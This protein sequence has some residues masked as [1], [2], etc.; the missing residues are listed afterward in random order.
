MLIPNEMNHDGYTLL[1]LTVWI[2]ENLKLVKCPRYGIMSC[3][4]SPYQDFGTHVPG[5]LSNENGLARL[6]PAM[7]HNLL[8]QRKTNLFKR[9]PLQAYALHG[10]AAEVDLASLRKQVVLRSVLRKFSL[11]QCYC[12]RWLQ[13]RRRYHL[14]QIISPSVATVRVV[15]TIPYHIITTISVKIVECG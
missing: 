6:D 10:D 13:A 11:R 12:I 2:S 15:L 7:N 8:A 1:R 4:C 3:L 9:L 5:S 14:A